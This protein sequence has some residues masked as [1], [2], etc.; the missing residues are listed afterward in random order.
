MTDACT[1]PTDGRLRYDPGDLRLAKL[2]AWQRLLLRMASRIRI[3]QLTVVL[4]GGT[5]VLF[6]SGER[7]ELRGEIEVLRIRAVR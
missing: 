3:G 4:P 5:R 1:H 2:G 6:D 7:P